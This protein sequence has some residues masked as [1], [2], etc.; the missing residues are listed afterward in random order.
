MGIRE[1]LFLVGMM[2]GACLSYFAKP[3]ARK[4]GKEEVGFKTAGL[5]ICLLFA[6]LLFIFA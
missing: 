4:A 3:I 5:F 1:I 6:V 2:G